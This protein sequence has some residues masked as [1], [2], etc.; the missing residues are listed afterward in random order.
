MT[1]LTNQP[2][3]PPRTALEPLLAGRKLALARALAQ[4]GLQLIDAARRSGEVRL[5]LGFARA[6]LTVSLTPTHP[7]HAALLRTDLWDLGY[8]GDAGGR[9]D[10]A[11]KLVA[12]V[13]KASALPEVARHLAGAL[14]G[15]DAG[16]EEGAAAD[17]VVNRA[18]PAVSFDPERCTKRPEAGPRQLGR[19]GLWVQTSGNQWRPVCGQTLQPDAAATAR[20]QGLALSHRACDGAWRVLQLAPA[21]QGCTVRSACAGCWQDRGTHPAIA[22]QVQTALTELGW[23]GALQV[24]GPEL[25]GALPTQTGPD[26]GLL[27]VSAADLLARPTRLAVARLLRASPPPHGVLIVGREPGALVAEGDGVAAPLAAVRA[28]QLARTLLGSALE[29]RAGR[30]PQRDARLDWW[31]L[32]GPRQAEQQQ[33][34]VEHVTLVLN[35]RC[36]TVCRYCDL[37]LRLRE[38]MP[39]ERV[40]RVLE[41]VVALGAKSLEFFGGE[42]TLRPDLFVLLEHARAL[43]LDTYVT[44]TGVG[45]SES[46]LTQLAQAGITDLSVSIDSADPAIHDN[47][48][49]REGMHAAAVHAARRLRALGASH[50]GLNTVV[51]PL[52][53]AGLPGVV[54]LAADLGLAGVTMFLC[55]PV[56]EF[57]N[58]TPLLDEAESLRLLTEIVPQCRALGEQLGVHV[59]VRP[60]VDKEADAPADVAK[61]IASGQYNRIFDGSAPCRMTG[62]L[63]AVRA[64]GTVRLCN[65]PVMQFDDGMAVGDLADAPLVEILRSQRVAAFRAAAGTLDLCRYCTFDHS[66][67]G[68]DPGL[69]VQAAGEGAAD[70]NRPERS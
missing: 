44:T 8:L 42:V 48:K 9:P 4:A 68:V 19:A 31:L 65:Q 17:H 30:W 37:P 69:R 32:A 46:Q 13:A 15:T 18:E 16:G 23:N 59:G 47:L 6:A 12:A 43:G 39:I 49:G 51:T 63:V 10:L 45:L 38:D 60:A 67:G 33:P 27:I 64:D 57:G 7:D 56:A 2:S 24:V 58:A 62:H 29:L 36:V 61:R 5:T 25:S 20:V 28:A 70:E 41:E 50:V 34:H 3:P 1:S 11:R 40:W 66:V 52:N 21:C 14:V 53:L 22:T 55:Q 54:Q 35:R 26:P